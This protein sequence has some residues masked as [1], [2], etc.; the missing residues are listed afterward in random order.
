LFVVFFIC[1]FLFKYARIY[2]RSEKPQIPCEKPQIPC[3]KPQIPCEKPQIP[4]E[5]P[6][7]PC[8]K[9]LDYFCVW[10]TIH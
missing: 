8:E 6:Q 1:L 2:I 5:K 9:P 3:E 7:I 10:I 4:C